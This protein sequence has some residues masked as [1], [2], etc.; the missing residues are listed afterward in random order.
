M[1]KAEKIY[2]KGPGFLRDTFQYIFPGCLFLSL[3]FLLLIYFIN[4]GE[5]R[6][7]FICLF[8]N[9]APNIASFILVLFLFFL[10]FGYL[11]GVLFMEVGD[12]LNC[13]I[14][15]R[16]RKKTFKDEMKIGINSPFILL[17][18]IER[19]NLLS[20]TKRNIAISFFFLSILSICFYISLPSKCGFIYTAIIAAIL[21]FL[22]IWFAHRAYKD[23]IERID[24]ALEMLECFSKREK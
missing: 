15:Y 22:F 17:Y 6:K 4:W 19:Y 5:F 2:E 18:Y 20:Y 23:F 16:L 7:E 3:S 11:L 8:K 21:F 14:K 12:I 10:I 13:C 24:A 1:D 9:N